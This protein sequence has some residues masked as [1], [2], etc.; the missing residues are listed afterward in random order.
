LHATCCGLVVTAVRQV[1]QLVVRLL[2]ALQL[3][4]LIFALTSDVTQ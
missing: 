2:F 4:Y 1:V 3:I